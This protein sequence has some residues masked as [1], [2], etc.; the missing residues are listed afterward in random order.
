MNTSTL[1]VLSVALLLGTTAFAGHL[2]TGHSVVIGAAQAASV[3]PVVGKP[4][5]QAQELAA[6]GDYKGAM[7]AVKQAEAAT[8]KT[9]DETKVIDQMRSYIASKSGN[10]STYEAQIAAGKGSASVARS[11]IRA[12]YM[13][14]E[15]AKVIKDAEVV[16]R[17]GAMDASTQTLIAQ[18]Y[19]L[20]GDY[21]G[22]IR[23]L[24]GRTDLDSVKLIYGAAFKL[25]DME[26]IQGALEQLILATGN[27]EYWRGGIE[28]AEHQRP[29]TD[30]QTLDL[31]RLR[32]LTGT[33]RP[34][35]GGDDD[36]SLAAQIAI[37]LGLPGEAQ[38][39]LQKG[40]TAGVV[41]G[42]R[43]NRLMAM[44]TTQATKQKAELAQMEARAKTP[45]DLVKV[46][47]AVAGFGD[48]A[49]ALE[50]IER[51]VKLSPAP[52]YETQV[53]LGQALL[54]NGKRDAAAKAFAAVPKTDI[55]AWNIA[56]LYNV[57]AR[58]NPAT[59]SSVKTPK[60]KK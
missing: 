9:A 37:Q 10:A 11:L 48:T 47:E 39:V 1:R 22:T 14:K 49:K 19:F 57:Y 12:H 51:A 42:E 31:L 52:V 23:Y 41:K 27:I 56:H 3:R 58:T 43:A 4:L 46:G 7:V 32:L 26:A 34:A 36:Y 15:Y 53:A 55:K 2:V 21:K 50:L 25:N 28:I 38:S 6:K 40:M 60:K 59:A 17:F 45:S 35:S 54:A 30:H 20:S 5:Q 13:Q 18:A 29:L 16:R 24:K 33:A 44:A 8:G